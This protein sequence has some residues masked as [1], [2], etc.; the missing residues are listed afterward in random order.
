MTNRNIVRSLG[1]FAVALLLGTSANAQLFRTYLASTGN[2]ANPCNLAQPCRLLPAALNAVTPG[3]EVWL[4]DSANYNTG[5]VTITKSVT[6]LAIPGAVGS[7]VS[8]G[9]QD[10][11]I[12]NAPGVLVNLRNLVF[13]ALGTSNNGVELEQGLTVNIAGCEFDNLANDAII[14]GAPSAFLNVKDTVIRNSG[15]GI[16]VQG[17]TEATIE[18]VQITGSAGEFGVVVDTGGRAVVAESTL[19]GMDNGAVAVG[20]SGAA[21]LVVDRSTIGHTSHAVYSQT[22]VPGD[23]AEVIVTRSVINNASTAAI[24]ADQAASSTATVTAGGNYMTEN[25]IGFKFAGGLIYSRGDNTLKY[26]TQDV[27][28][29]GLTPL[30]GM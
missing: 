1:L 25:N 24:T 2:D 26:N 27:N 30:T 28:G 20:F 22:V 29:G 17:G 21:R 8:T 7:V 4:L 18:R 16:V 5:T 6:I 15:V 12:V 11:L 19:S 13:V 10:A 3:G 14:A 9:G 23:V